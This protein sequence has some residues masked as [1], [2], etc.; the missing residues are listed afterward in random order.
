MLRTIET[1]YFKVS[2]P[3]HYKFKLVDNYTGFNKD[4]LIDDFKRVL[5]SSDLSI[6]VKRDIK[7]KYLLGE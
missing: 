5:L 4:E 3:S 1:K 2:Q 7:I 6:E